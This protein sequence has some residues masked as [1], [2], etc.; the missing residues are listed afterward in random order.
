MVFHG[1]STAAALLLSRGM[2]ASASPPFTSLLSIFAKLILGTGL[3]GQ[4]GGDSILV[5]TD[6]S[7]SYEHVLSV[8]FPAAANKRVRSI[9]K[10]GGWW[11]QGEK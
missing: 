8:F 7:S 2:S 9:W 4:A 5:V 1:I 3:D 6:F 11:Q 10:P